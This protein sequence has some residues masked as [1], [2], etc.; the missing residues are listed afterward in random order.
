MPL[1]Q[2][3]RLAEFTPAQIT[4]HRATCVNDRTGEM[5]LTMLIYASI[6]RLQPD[7]AMLAVEAILKSARARNASHGLTGAL[8]FTGQHFVQVLEGRAAA[9][10]ALWGKLQIDPRHA[11]LVLTYHGPLEKRRFGDWGMA[12]AGPSQ[13]VSKRVHSMFNAADP[14]A[15]RRATHWLLDLMYQFNKP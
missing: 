1:T 10:D 6:S 13:F 8:L 2:R 12:Y 15:Q 11:G 4:E 9:I 14:A 3:E 7:A 5:P